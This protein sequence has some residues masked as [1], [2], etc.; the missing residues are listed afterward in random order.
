DFYSLLCIP[1]DAPST[2]IKIAYHR[3]LLLSHPDKQF[4]PHVGTSGDRSRPGD[5]DIALLKEAYTILSDPSS[6]AAYD[7]LLRREANAKSRGPRPAQVVSLEEFTPEERGEDE[8]E[9][10]TGQEWHYG[11]RCGGTYRITEDDMENG[12][13]LVGCESCSEVIWVGYE[14]AEDEGEP[15]RDGGDGDTTARYFYHIDAFRVSLR[16]SSYGTR[17]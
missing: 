17:N 8:D 1:R 6:R 4:R 2:D 3:I 11:C 15:V 10:T 16:G 7:R 14:L 13:H 5:V 12:K 9:E